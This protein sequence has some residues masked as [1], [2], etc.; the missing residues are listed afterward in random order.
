MGVQG[1]GCCSVLYVDTVSSLVTVDF[2]LAFHL[3]SFSPS[4]LQ[5][6]LLIL[7]TCCL[8]SNSKGRARVLYY[9]LVQ[10]LTS[11]AA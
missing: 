10:N 9:M 11:W 5:S 2:P 7:S 1:S 4:I 8:S 3:F 6:Y